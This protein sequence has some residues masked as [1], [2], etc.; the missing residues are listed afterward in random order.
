MA[1]AKKQQEAQQPE[2]S[3]PS[4]PAIEGFIETRSAADIGETFQNL[5]DQLATLKGPRAEQAK[6]VGKAIERTEELLSYLMQVKE[7]LESDRK[8]KGGGRK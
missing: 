3:S 7:K 6:K 1:T 5:K 4:Y 2:I 8:G